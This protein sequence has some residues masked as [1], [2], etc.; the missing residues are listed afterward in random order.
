MAKQSYGTK[1]REYRINSNLSQ[2]EIESLA[3]LSFGTL[4]K[5]ENNKLTPGRK[6]ILKVCRIMQADLIETLDLLEVELH[7]PELIS[8][9][10]VL[11]SKS[12]KY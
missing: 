2:F 6:T 9:T 4:S 11:L 1:F 5:I 7:Y 12:E 3:G 10:K 8:R